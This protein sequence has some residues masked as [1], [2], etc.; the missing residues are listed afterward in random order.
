MLLPA[1][2]ANGLFNFRTWTSSS[3]PSSPPSFSDH[4]PFSFVVA[5]VTTPDVRFYTYFELTFT[6]VVSEL[7]LQLSEDSQKYP[8]ARRAFF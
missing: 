2:E 7:A 6:P 3:P 4:A 5:S 1:P 8:G